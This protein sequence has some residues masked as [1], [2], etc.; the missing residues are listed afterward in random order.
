V[1]R[2]EGLDANRE[3]FSDRVRD[4]HDLWHVLTGYGRDE[5]GEAAN[6]AFTFGQMPLR[7][8][9]LILFGIAVQTPLDPRGRRPWYRYLHR[10]WQRGRRAAW[11]P[12][13]R[14]ENLLPRPLEEVRRALA[15]DP[16]A[17]VHPEGVIVA[18][19][20]DRAA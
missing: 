12:L 20:A 1:Q 6:L 17:S 18:N 16:A 10:A 14:Y 7:G 2:M 8:I 15:I 3:W 13:A 5:A 19:G 11:L 9:G 4:V